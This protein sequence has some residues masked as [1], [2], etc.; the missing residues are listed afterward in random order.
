[1]SRDRFD[2][3][4][5]RPVCRPRLS[6]PASP[7]PDLSDSDVSRLPDSWCHSSVTLVH[8]FGRRRGPER[9]CPSSVGSVGDGSLS[10]RSLLY[11]RV[12]R[13]GTVSPTLISAG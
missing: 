2:P 10:A 7:R 8:E 6:L 4:L 5:S 9:S 11:F 12:V 13:F 3:C 1:M